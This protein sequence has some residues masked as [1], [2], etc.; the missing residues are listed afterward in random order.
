VGL[1]R[2][3]SADYG[4][5]ARQI[6]ATDQLIDRIVYGLYGL[7]EDEIEIVAGRV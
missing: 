3:H 5:L 1:Y 2:A 4:R 7:T 6:E